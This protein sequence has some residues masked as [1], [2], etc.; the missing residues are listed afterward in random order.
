MSMLENGFEK[1]LCFNTCVFVMN[2]FVVGFVLIMIHNHFDKMLVW[3]LLF[4]E[5][6][7]KKSYSGVHSKKPTFS[8]KLNVY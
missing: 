2:F 1:F 8:V 5:M 7:A 3:F 4:F 6:S